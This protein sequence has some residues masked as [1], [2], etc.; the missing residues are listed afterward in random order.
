MSG[1]CYISPWD[2]F[3]RLRPVPHNSVSVTELEQVK[4]IDGQGETRGE[5]VRNNTNQSAETTS[6]SIQ[7]VVSQYTKPESKTE[8]LFLKCAPQ[9]L[10]NKECANYAFKLK[11]SYCTLFLLKKK[12][13]K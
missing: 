10:I 12:E 5:N 8:E 9:N 7:Y 11:Y 6:S 13:A 2:L 1:G 3:W 4:H